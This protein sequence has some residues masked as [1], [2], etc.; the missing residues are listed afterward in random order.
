MSTS[1]FVPTIENQMRYLIEWFKEFSEMQ[2]ND[3][4]PII[5]QKFGPKGYVNGLITSMENLSNLGDDRPPSLFQCRLKLFHEWTETWNDNDK[6]QLLN[7]I[8]LIDPTFSAKYEKEI[9]TIKL[10][11]PDDNEE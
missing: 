6:E 2:R 7:H 8:K 11:V 10:A 9:D 4:L 5:V 1:G 3:F